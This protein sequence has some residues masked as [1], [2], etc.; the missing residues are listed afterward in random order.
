MEDRKTVFNNYI[1][2]FKDLN[3]KDKKDEL[4]N[5]IKELIV[6]FDEM[7]KQEGIQLDYLQSRE[8]LDLNSDNV[9]EDD[10][11]EACLVYVEIAKD[12]IGQY[13][14]EKL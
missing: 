2:A 7:S 1:N 3:T 11:L 13:L 6:I 4:I 5:S 12:I 9:S 8:I 14:E 10:Y